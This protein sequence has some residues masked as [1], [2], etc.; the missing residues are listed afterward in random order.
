MKDVWGLVWYILISTGIVVLLLKYLKHN[1]NE[2]ERKDRVLKI[3]AIATLI[4]HYSSLYVDYFS[5]IE[6][7]VDGTMLLPIFPCNLAMWMLVVVAFIKN[8]NTKFFTILAEMTFYIGTVGG[9]VGV[10]LNE[11][12]FNTPSLSDWYVLKGLLSH[13][14]MLIGCLY[15]FVGDYIKIRVKN[16]CSISLALLILMMDGILTL[17]LFDLFGLDLPNAMYLVEAPYESMPFVNTWTLGAA[18]LIVGFLIT[19]GYEHVKLEKS[20]RWITKFKEK[21]RKK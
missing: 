5:N 12:Y 18:G 21:R 9:I 2:K 6:A 8:K 10:V 15:L 11:A 16:M 17:M 20:E 14:T 19:L 7:S 3:S 13:T 1:V 4:L